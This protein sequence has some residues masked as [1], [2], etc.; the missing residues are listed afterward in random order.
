MGSIFYIYLFLFIIIRYEGPSILTFYVYAFRYNK[1]FYV[2]DYFN[3]QSYSKTLTSP[4]RD[5]SYK[6]I[7][8][9]CT[10]MYI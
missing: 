5:I 8:N 9:I 7:L 2:L 6:K 10:H 1:Y 3:S 4:T